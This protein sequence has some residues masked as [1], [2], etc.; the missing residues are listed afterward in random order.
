VLVGF[1][2]GSGL[3]VVAAGES[4]LRP[5][6]G[7]VLAVA[8]TENEEYVRDDRTRVGREP[9]KSSDRRLATLRPYEVLADL[10]HLPLAVIQS[11]KDAYLPAARARQ[12]FG[13]DREGRRLYA[14]TAGSH[15]FAGARDTLYE[16]ARLALEWIESRDSGTAPAGSASSSHGSSR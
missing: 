16:R 4:E 11:T 5:L 12:L 6:L 7:G 14:I 1:S 2:R 13:P 9:R 10:D 8:L 3:A 15:T